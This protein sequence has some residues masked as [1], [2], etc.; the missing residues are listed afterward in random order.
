M[1]PH[2]AECC[3]VRPL[4]LGKDGG[5]LIGREPD[6]PGL[7]SFQTSGEDHSV[8]IGP[9][10]A[11]HRRIALEHRLHRV[12]PRLV[13]LH[14]QQDVRIER[15]D[16]V[17]QQLMAP[18]LHQDV[19][20][21]HPHFVLSVGGKF[22]FNTVE[23]R[24]GCDPPELVS[25]G[26]DH[27]HGKQQSRRT[28]QKQCG[29]QHEPAHRSNLHA[30]EIHGAYPP[31]RG[32]PHRQQCH[33]NNQDGERPQDASKNEY[34]HVGVSPSPARSLPAVPSADHAD[35]QSIFRSFRALLPGQDD[36]SMT[37][38]RCHMEIVVTSYPCPG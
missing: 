24:V 2:E 28:G 25:A 9:R 20:G 11:D 18:V 30:R 19:R 38:A 14:Q 8:V 6:H 27:Q 7:V 10:L 29:N 15:I 35:A 21:Q 5:G 1:Q 17:D 12:I 31:C 34:S 23:W 37:A 33:S 4:Q 3:T 36:E 13:H 22:H 16:G 26:N 32:V